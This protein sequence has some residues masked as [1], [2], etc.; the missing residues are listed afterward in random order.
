VLTRV[1]VLVTLRAVLLVLLHKNVR[2]FIF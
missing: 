2:K 1:H